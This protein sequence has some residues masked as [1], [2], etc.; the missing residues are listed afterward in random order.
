MTKPH[1]RQIHKVLDTRGGAHAYALGYWGMVGWKRKILMELSTPLTV[2]VTS[3]WDS[4]MSMVAGESSRY[5][6]NIQYEFDLGL[7]NNALC[8]EDGPS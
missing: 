2:V 7:Y 5:V 3:A 4:L 8:R 1:G 6:E